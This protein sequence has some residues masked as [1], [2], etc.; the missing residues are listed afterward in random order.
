MMWRV[1][2]IV[3][4]LVLSAFFVSSAGA[5]EELKIL[6]DRLLALPKIETQAGF[7][8][9]VLVPPGHLYDPLFMLPRDGRVWVSDDGSE[10]G[11]KGG[12]LVSVDQA[13]TVTVLADTGTLLPILGFDVAP[14]GFGEFTGHIF[15]LAQAKVKME[16]ALANHVIQRLDPK[17]DYAASVFCPLPTA[18]EVNRGAAGAGVE[19]RFGPEGSPFAGKFFSVTAYN[20]TIYQT[21]ADGQCTPFITFDNQQ[22]G[23]PI[24]LTFSPDGKFLLV[25]VVRG[26]IFAG[27]GSVIVRVRPDR[28]VEDKPLAETQ[29]MFG[30]L[31]FAPEGFGPYAGQIFVTEVGT[32]DLPVPMTQAVVAD[33][34]V[35]RITPEGTLALVAT[36]FINPW[37]LRF[38]G[39]TLWVT[40]INGDFI[41]GRR[42]L[43][44]GFIIAI[45][46][47]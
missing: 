47:Q 13:G 11:E 19:A 9:I 42:E 5:E 28:T 45:T 29:T 39:N 7:T 38:I 17:Q 25:T 31:D 36:G 3:V 35:Q 2:H 24:G 23:A 21:T 27:A 4:G 46:V 30:S 14:K 20:N 40:D 44:D 26:G 10:K 12:R 15:S 18:G 1:W 8:A 33:G 32:Y 43:P 6:L 34:K 16:G 41:G 37:S 22:F